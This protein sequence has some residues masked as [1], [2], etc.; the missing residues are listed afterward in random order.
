MIWGDQL[1]VV[2]QR[3]GVCMETVKG[4]GLA[5]EQELRQV[6]NRIVKEEMTR[7]EADS[8]EMRAL[9]GLRGTVVRSVSDWHTVR[10][11]AIFV[12]F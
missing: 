11:R 2:E 1:T 6:A 12:P 10:L 4:Y 8:D 7:A 9:E 5:T 3:H